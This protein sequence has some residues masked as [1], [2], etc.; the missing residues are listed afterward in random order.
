MLIFTYPLSP[1]L[2]EEFGFTLWTFLIF[3]FEGGNFALYMPVTIQLFGIS[4]SSANFGVVA[5][6]YALSNVVNIYYLS[7]AKV[8][9]FIFTVHIKYS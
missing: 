5:T 6:V 3:I 2:G 1:Q 4:N 8:T 7:R 9:F